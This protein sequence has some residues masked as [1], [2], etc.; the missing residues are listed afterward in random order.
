M[1]GHIFTKHALL[2]FGACYG[3][4]YGLDGIS[5]MFECWRRLRLLEQL[6]LTF[7]EQ[8]PFDDLIKVTCILS[9]VPLYQ[10]CKSETVAYFDT[11]DFGRFVNI[12]HR[13]WMLEKMNVLYPQKSLRI[14]FFFKI[15]CRF[16][17]LFPVKRIHISLNVNFG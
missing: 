7:W 3:T 6:G 16:H 9:V 14:W 11:G 1:T 8:M 12:G 5:H 13:I 17:L 15:I 10:N 4:Q 2:D